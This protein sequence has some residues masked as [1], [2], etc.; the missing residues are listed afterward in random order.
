METTT[1]LII[2]NMALTVV[3]SPLVLAIVEIMKRVKKSKCLC[4]DCELQE[5]NKTKSEAEIKK[6]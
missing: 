5:L 6:E 4:M 2:V 3:I 1:V